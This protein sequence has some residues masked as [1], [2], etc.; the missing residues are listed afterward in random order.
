M[1]K[2]L[3]VII[4]DWEEALKD[5]DLIVETY[6]QAKIGELECTMFEISHPKAREPYK[7]HRSRLYIEKKT[8]LPI[9][10]E[11]YAHPAK[12]GEEAALVEEY[13]Y[14]DLKV[15]SPPADAEFDVEN[16]R[17]GFK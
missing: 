8:N 10:V 2:M 15:E 4:A 9:R 17:Y 6:P 11:Q 5:P 12:A 13:T 3:D 7:F 14:S 16:A 1:E